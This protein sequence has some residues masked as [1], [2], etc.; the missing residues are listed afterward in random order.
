MAD[1]GVG[2]GVHYPIPVHMQP[3]YKELGYNDSL[4]ESEKAAAEVISLPVHPS[5]TEQDLVTIANAVKQ[6]V[7]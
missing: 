7:G 2:V 5:L 3:M 1:L 6:I 4:P